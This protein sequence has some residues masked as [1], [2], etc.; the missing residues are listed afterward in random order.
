MPSGSATTVYTGFPNRLPSSPAVLWY[1]PSLRRAHNDTG[2]GKYG[3]YCFRAA[4]CWFCF[5][6]AAGPGHTVSGAREVPGS[7]LEVVLG[8]AAG[9]SGGMSPPPQIWLSRLVLWQVV[10]T[11]CVSKATSPQGIMIVGGLVCP[12]PSLSSHAVTTPRTTVA[13]P[14][15]A[16]PR[17][18]YFIGPVC[19]GYIARN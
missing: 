16:V 7:L 9:L 5:L 6:G 3:A 10:A 12:S 2:Q 14:E 11:L 8:S 1:R 17:Y 13:D 19:V 4:S 18:F 15:D